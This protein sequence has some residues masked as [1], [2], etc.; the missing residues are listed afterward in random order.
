MSR[1]NVECYVENGKLVILLDLALIATGAG[2]RG[3]D[4][5]GLG[6]QKGQA[7]V[8]TP[9][10]SPVSIPATPGPVQFA[11]GTQQAATPVFTPE[12]QKAM[13]NVFNLPPALNAV[14]QPPA[15]QPVP[16]NSARLA[17]D[18]IAAKKEAGELPANILSREEEFTRDL[19]SL[20]TLAGGEN[21]S[22][23]AEDI[24]FLNGITD[25]I[26]ALAIKKYS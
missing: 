18:W 26:R 6:G 11:Q 2:Q 19:I 7:A 15:Q 8:S 23:D 10:P 16:T 20:V 22:G 12:A 21:I 25:Q 17:T 5:G 24:S 3:G 14:E 13:D 9:F 1:E 4:S